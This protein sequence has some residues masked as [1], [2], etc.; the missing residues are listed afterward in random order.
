MGSISSDVNRAAIARGVGGTASQSSPAGTRHAKGDV[1]E[2][3][4]RLISKRKSVGKG[5][6]T[7]KGSPGMLSWTNGEMWC[8]DKMDPRGR[9]A[10]VLH[11]G[12]GQQDPEDLAELGALAGEITPH[13]HVNVDE[14]R[15][16][17]RVRQ[18][19]ARV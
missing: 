13:C 17:T 8:V 18:P 4:A 7:P 12:S 6:R 10:W 19:Q 3:P 9:E 11:K 15:I 16:A 2:E 5:T 1:P 14:G